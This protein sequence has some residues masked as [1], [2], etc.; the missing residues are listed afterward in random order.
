MA[1]E[2]HTNRCWAAAVALVF[3]VAAP[4]VSAATTAGSTDVE[5]GKALAFDR[6][7]GNCLACHVI[8]G[9]TQPGNLGPPLRDMKSRFP[10]RQF[11]FDRIWDEQKF[12]PYT[13]MP[14]FGKNHGL[15]KDEIN[16]IVDFLYTL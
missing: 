13:A 6:A 9:G 4:L 2:K 15:S 5:K 10:S 8:A 1:R 12:N 11:L 14:P 3:A 7:K 16:Q